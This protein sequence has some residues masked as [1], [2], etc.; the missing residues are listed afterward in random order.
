M[1]TLNFNND[2]KLYIQIYNYFVNEIK[3]GN[4]KSNDKL[5]SRRLFAQNLGVSLNTVKNAYEQLLDEGYIVSR[6]FR[7]G[8]GLPRYLKSPL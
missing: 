4:L 3:S 8:I 5:P 6:L 1:I 7:A 2:E